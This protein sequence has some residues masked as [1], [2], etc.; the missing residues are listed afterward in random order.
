MSLPNPGIGSENCVAFDSKFGS[1]GGV[2][3]TFIFFFWCL[4]V[5]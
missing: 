3:G 4:Q 1:D 5:R 2:V